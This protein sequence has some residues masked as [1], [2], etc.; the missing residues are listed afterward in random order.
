MSTDLDPDDD[1]DDLFIDVQLSPQQ[2]RVMTVCASRVG[3]SLDGW[4]KELALR[5]VN[6]H[7]STLS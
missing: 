5:E 6:E 7:R 4:L 1:D 2:K 3:L